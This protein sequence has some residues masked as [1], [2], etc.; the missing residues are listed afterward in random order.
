MGKYYIGL[1]VGTNSVGWAVTNEDYDLLRLKGK[2][3]WG[4]R[5]FSEANDKKTRRGFRSAR[6]RVARRK[7]RINLLNDIFAKEISEIDN[8]FFARLDNASYL[9]VDKQN[10][11]LSRNLLF[12]THE[13]EKEF[14]KLVIDY[15]R[16]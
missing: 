7:Y 15:L 5:I 2:H 9:F 8:T 11:G 4:A 13:E 12:K 3:A 1:D 14:Y 10:L 16:R 6:R